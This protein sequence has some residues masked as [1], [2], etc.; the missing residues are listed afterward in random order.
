[1]LHF[2]FTMNNVACIFAILSGFYQVFFFLLLFFIM[3]FYIFKVCV[4]MCAQC[5]QR[6][7]FARARHHIQVLCGSCSTVLIK[8]LLNH[9]CIPFCIIIMTI[10]CALLL[11]SMA[12]FSCYLFCIFFIILHTLLNYSAK[13]LFMFSFI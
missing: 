11:N 8:F 5:E 9:G 12:L 3:L 7:Y 2:F 1:M 6:L 4:C 10:Q 13:I